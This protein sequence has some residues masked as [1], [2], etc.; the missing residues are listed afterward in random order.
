MQPF[1]TFVLEVIRETEKSAFKEE[2]ISINEEK[3]SVCLVINNKEYFMS[4]TFCCFYFLTCFLI[5]SYS[6]EGKEREV[7]CICRN[8]QQSKLHE[9]CCS[10][11][12]LCLLEKI[13][14]KNHRII[15]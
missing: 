10:Q 2:I 11:Q 12:I 1:L 15:E 6:D 8:C 4:P 3:K 9:D 13:A 5:R 7:G 14:L